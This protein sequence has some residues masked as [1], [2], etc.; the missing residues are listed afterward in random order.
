MPQAARCESVA[1]VVEI[2][3]VVVVVVDRLAFLGCRVVA[4]AVVVE[5]PVVEAAAAVVVVALVAAAVL[6]VVI[7]AAGVGIVAQIAVL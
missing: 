3:P 5:R 4:A 7:V 1:S 2:E 6:V